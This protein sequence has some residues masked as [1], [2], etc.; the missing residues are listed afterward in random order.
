M[1]HVMLMLYLQYTD[2]SPARGGMSY[3][4]ELLG[5]VTHALLLPL[6]E[7]V[8]Q[9]LLPTGLPLHLAF[10]EGLLDLPQVIVLL[11]V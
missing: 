9:V 2:E 7:P 5:C 1:Q 10:R 8:V 4:L 11:C 3:L 6:G